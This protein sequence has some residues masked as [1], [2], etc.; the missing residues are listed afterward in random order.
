MKRRDLERKLK[1][2]GWWQITGSKHDKWTDGINAVAVPRH[3][4]INEYTAKGILKEV[5]QYNK[6]RGSK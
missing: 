1:Q 5:E 4:E 2:L 3:R 6:I